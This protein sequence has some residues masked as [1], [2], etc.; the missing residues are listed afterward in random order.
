[1]GRGVSAVARGGGCRVASP[2]SGGGVWGPLSVFASW[3]CEEGEKRCPLTST[4]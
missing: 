1:M 3:A 4:F 2:T